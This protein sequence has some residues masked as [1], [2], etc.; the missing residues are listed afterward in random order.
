VGPLARPWLLRGAVL[1]LAIA[2]GLIAW[3]A[4]EGESEPP[5]AAPKARLLD[6]RELANLPALLGHPVYWAGRQPRAELELTEHEDGSVQVRYLE[7]GEAGPDEALTVG[8][9]P[10]PDPRA[11]LATFAAEPGSLVRRSRNGL[12]VF[13]NEANRSSVYFASPDNSVQ[14]EVYDPSPARALELALSGR[15]RPAG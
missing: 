10:L 9:Y 1:A 11:A 14:V 4:G 2:V 5:G 7:P 8:T 12:E 15:V 13:S 6:E 3:I